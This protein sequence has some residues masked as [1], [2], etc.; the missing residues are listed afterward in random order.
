M[1][2]DAVL[3]VPPRSFLSRLFGLYLAPGESFADIV[4]RP[5]FWAPLALMVAVSL[6]FSGVWLQKVDPGEFVKGMLEESGRWDQIPADRRGEILETVGR[7]FPIQV[8]VTAAIAPPVIVLLTAAV[9]LFVFRFFYAGDVNF[10]KAMSLV[11]YSLAAVGLVQTPLMLLVMA[12]KGDWNL[13]PRFILQANATLLVAKES[14][15]KPLYA[16]LGSLD[17]F[18]FWTMGLLAL[19]FGLA[20]RRPLGSALWGVVIPW[21]VLVALK[22]GAA[23]LF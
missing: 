22:V 15:A 7:R 17:V 14:V 11:A 10:T 6:A 16:L 1:G 4:R 2:S 8:W 18:E 3:E 23:A 19:G 20:I 12:L 9:L 21:V 13:D 5:G